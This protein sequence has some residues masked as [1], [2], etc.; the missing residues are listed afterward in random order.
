MNPQLK[1]LFCC[2]NIVKMLWFVN[3]IFLKKR[4]K[5]KKKFTHPIV[6]TSIGKHLRIMDMQ[7]PSLKLLVP[8][9]VQLSKRTKTDNIIWPFFFM[10]VQLITNSIIS[11]S[12]K[13]KKK[14]FKSTFLFWE[15]LRYIFRFYGSHKI[16]EH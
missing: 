9:H 10:C 11:F 7:R 1:L 14:S 6:G 13:K 8:N 4:Q 3:I 16:F 5:R 15:N 2:K 12:Q